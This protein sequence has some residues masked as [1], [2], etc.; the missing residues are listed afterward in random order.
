MTRRAGLGG[1]ALSRRFAAD[2]AAWL[3]KARSPLVKYRTAV[4]LLGWPA[5]APDVAGWWARRYEDPDLAAVAAAQN[6]DGVWPSPSRFY[7]RRPSLVVPRYAATAWQ[8]P[9]LADMGC[10][11]DED[12]VARAAAALRARRTADG[13]FDLGA[14]GV[15]T[16]AMAVVVRSL[17]AFGPAAGELGE[18]RRWLVARQRPDG[19]WAD[20]DELAASDAPS[21]V[22]T[23][24][25]VL[26]AL[27]GDDASAAARS[28]GVRYLAASY[29]T[30]YNGRFPPSAAAWRRLSWPQYRFDA[31]S[32]ATAMWAA[33]ASR[34]DV[35]PFAEAVRAAQTRR[36]FWRQQFAFG[37]ES[38]LTPVGAGRASRWIT[39]DA[40][41]LLCWYY[42][43]AGERDCG[44]NG[45]LL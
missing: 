10:G 21:T 35:G 20:D 7:G 32:V 41:R 6:A 28:A 44:N 42:G 11:L 22:G 8:L 38:R 3:L 26:R 33:G 19:G 12:V 31:L 4:D 1:G 15:S 43:A 39:L 24:A 45:N 18:T 27:A 34:R 30:S 17:A 37:G 23:T 13:A 29:S 40:A 25:E 2:P 16:L 9:I 5:D 36:G 14:G